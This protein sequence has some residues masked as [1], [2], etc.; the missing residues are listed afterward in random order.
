MVT[1]FD[2]SLK[3]ISTESELSLQWWLAECDS[4]LNV[5]VHRGP[6]CFVVAC[7]WQGS[8]DGGTCDCFTFVSLGPR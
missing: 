3:T 8:L 1:V 5:R 4:S 7:Y 6:I 2:G